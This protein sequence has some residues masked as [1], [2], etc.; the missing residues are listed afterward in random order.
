[1]ERSGLGDGLLNMFDS[2]EEK[3]KN[4][5]RCKKITEKIRELELEQYHLQEK[6]REMG[7]NDLL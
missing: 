1:M 4:E 6:I 5:Y 3:S 7:G 2:P